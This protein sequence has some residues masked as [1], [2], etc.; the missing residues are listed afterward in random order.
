MK[1][2]EFYAVTTYDE[3][4]CA[5]LAYLMLNK[6]RR[7]PRM[8]ILSTGIVT[9]VAAGMIMLTEGRVSALPFL[10]MILGSM[11]CMV[12]FNLRLVTT[13]LLVA[14]YGSH[15]PEFHYVFSQ[16]EILVKHGEQKK[17]YTYG[18]VMRLLEMSGFLF[19]FMKDGQ[20]YILR[21]ADVKEGYSQL[22]ELLENKV[23][24][25]A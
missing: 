22:K 8:A 5:A 4:V 23:R 25:A 14:Q 3:Q 24:K 16:D 10:I 13:K 21:Q 11:L 18:Y 7:W 1:H 15:W 20:V 2:S 6:L 19:M 12:G 9:A 17:Q